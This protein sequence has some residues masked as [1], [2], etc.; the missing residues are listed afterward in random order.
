MT[1]NIHCFGFDNLD[2]KLL[3][4]PLLERILYN[5]ILFLEIYNKL[6]FNIII[7]FIY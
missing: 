2:L 5:L 3:I 7:S 6:N 1:L 4:L